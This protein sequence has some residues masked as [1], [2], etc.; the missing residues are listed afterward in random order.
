M[1]SADYTDYNTSPDFYVG[2]KIN[3]DFTDFSW[4]KLWDIM[5]SVF[6]N[7][8][9][10]SQEGPKDSPSLNGRVSLSIDGASEKDSVSSS[11]VLSNVGVLPGYESMVFQ[12]VSSDDIEKGIEGTIKEN[13]L[14]TVSKY[15]H[16]QRERTAAHM[17]MID[18]L[19]DFKDITGG[20][21]NDGSTA[22]RRDGIDDMKRKAQLLAYDTDGLKGDG[23]SYEMLHDE[24]QPIVPRFFGWVKYLLGK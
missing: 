11:P 24:G 16:E 10:W 4:S 19:K 15:E 9:N 20:L 2:G 21:K 18:R 5:T 3:F 6:W 23:S 7:C 13:I 22:T 14:G 1:M 8:F 17:S 12:A